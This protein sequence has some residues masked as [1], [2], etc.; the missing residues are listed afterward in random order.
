MAAGRCAG[1]SG[2]RISNFSQ[3]IKGHVLAKSES[4]MSLSG[5]ESEG[6]GTVKQRMAAVGGWLC[7][8][9]LSVSAPAMAA[10]IH[11]HIPPVLQER[12]GWDGIAVG[13]MVFKYYAV[14]AAHQTSYQCG[15]VQSGKPCAGTANCAEC[16]APD[17]G[18]AAMAYMLAQYPIV[19]T[20]GG[21][22]GDIALT[23]Q[24]KIGGLTEAEVKR[25]LK[26]GRPIIAGLSPAGFN[27]DRAPHHVAL[28]TGY[29]DGYGDLML[30]VN[31]PFPFDDERL[32]KGGNPYYSKGRSG[33]IEGQYDIS[34]E[35]FRTALNW[36]KTW[37]QITCAGRDCP[38][39]HHKVLRDSAWKDDRRAMQTVLAAS[40]DDFKPLRI[41]HKAADLAAGTTWQS[42]VV[43]SGA[44]QC[45]VREK[46]ESHRAE[47]RCLF[48]FANRSVVDELVQDML[49]RLRDSLPQGWVGEKRNENS[50]TAQYT[51]TEKFTAAKPGSHTM[52]SLYV[53]ERKKDRQVKMY[54]TVE[55]K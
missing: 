4:R 28:I 45:L 53:I 18:D 51:R 13:E 2:F 24:L 41:G 8:L 12:A 52:L 17:A 1:S 35:Q 9:L 16:P 10:T 26:E 42:N 11:L 36:T 29:D 34:L 38:S 37:Y 15:I 6:D 54:L 40:A 48:T 27:S 22:T 19:A 5:V 23:A 44:K 33:E 21:K 32:S 49:E 30:T 55:N 20:Q 43:F 25:E 7:V 31:D 46:D 50:S 39:N 14:P 47:W 3:R